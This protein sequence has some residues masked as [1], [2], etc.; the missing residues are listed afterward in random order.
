MT[1]KWNMTWGPSGYDFAIKIELDDR[2]NIYLVG[3]T[4]SYGSGGKDAFV[5]KFGIDSDGDGL[6]DDTEIYTTETSP[7]DTDTD[8]DGTSDS[9]EVDGGTN[10]LDPSSYPGQQL[11]RIFLDFKYIY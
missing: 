5:L 10:P 3:T 9:D 11:P 4:I 7:Y 1:P 2:K 6:T 8:N